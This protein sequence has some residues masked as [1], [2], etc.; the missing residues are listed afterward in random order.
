MLDNLMGWSARRWALIGVAF[1]A[2]MMGVALVLEH[3][4]G[5]EPCPLCIFQRVAVL[6]TAAVL[7]VAALHDPGGRGGVAYG[8]LGLVAVATGVGVAGRHVW[9]QH[10]PPDQVPSCGPGLDYMFEVLPLQR[11]LSQVLSGS[12]ECAEIG[13]LFLGLSLPAWTLIGFLVLGLSPLMLCLR[14]SAA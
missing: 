12:G 6:A 7:V 4:A 14:R 1:A 8:L 3:V 10:L 13:V 11:V 5:L 9:L 2:L